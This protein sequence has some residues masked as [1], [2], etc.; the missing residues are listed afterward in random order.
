[1]SG[2]QYRNLKFFSYDSQKAI[3]GADA[4][5]RTM[6]DWN[7]QINAGSNCIYY[8]NGV[9]LSAVRKTE[10]A[11]VAELKQFFKNNLFNNMPGLSTERHRRRRLVRKTPN[12]T[13]SFDTV[14]KRHRKKLKPK[15]RAVSS[16]DRANLAADQACLHW[17]QAGIQH[18][19]Y[20]H[21]NKYT[22]ENF[23]KIGLPEPKSRVNFDTVKG[24]VKI[25]EENIIKAWNENDPK[26][27]APK[28]HTLGEAAPESYYAK[29]HTSYLFTPE[30]IQVK[31]LVIDCPSI[32]LA[33]IF[34][35]RP[36]S[37]QG[38]RIENSFLRSLY[39]FVAGFGAKTPQTTYDITNDKADEKDQK[40]IELTKPKGG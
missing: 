10:F 24:G 26:G 34:D 36:K 18:A 3:E 33:P 22:L 37:E 8:I 25:T 40:T 38:D 7:R 29:T 32:A 13:A 15:I 27:G 28:K 11:D 30:T 39:S 20:Q 4:G 17:H 2:H 12:L 23:P 5:K 35:T 31:D 6:N 9:Q 16:R 19:T 1:M 21:A 14:A